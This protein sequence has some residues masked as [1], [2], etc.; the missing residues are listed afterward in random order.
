MIGKTNN[1]KILTQW[2]AFNEDCS[3]VR[4]LSVKV[5]IEYTIFDTFRCE[6]DANAK[7]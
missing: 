6:I 4:K 7:V 2:T 3:F 5:A 1:K